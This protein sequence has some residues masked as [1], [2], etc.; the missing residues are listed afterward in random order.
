MVINAFNSGARIYMADFEDA[1]SPTWANVVGGQQ[2]LT[3][4]I[5]RTISLEQGEKRYSLNDEVA[6]LL[7]RP[8]GWHLQERHVVVDG[9]HVSGG[10]FD[11]GVYLARNA[12][13]LLERGSGP[14]FYLPKLESHLEARLWNDVFCFAQDRLG[15]PRGT[16]K[17]TVLIETILAAFEMEEILYELREHSAGLNAGR[18]DYIFSVIKKFRDRPEFVLPDRAQ[19]T[20]TVPFMRAYT[21]LLVKTCHRRGAHAIGGMA[22]FIPSRRDAEVNEVALARVTRGQAARGRRRLRRL[23]GRPSRPRSG[24]DGRVRRGARRAAE[25][26]RAAARGRRDAGGRSS[27][28]RCDARRDHG[29][30]RPRRTS[31]SASATSPRGY[32]ASVPLRSTT[33]WRTPR[34]PRSRAR[35]SGS[36]FA[37][38]ASSA[39]TSSGSSARSWPSSRTS[40]CTARRARS[41]RRWRCEEVFVDFLTLTAYAQLLAGRGGLMSDGT[42]ADDIALALEE[43][44]V[45][46]EI[47]PGS[48]LRQEHLSE[49]FQVSRTPV[50]EALRRLAA[51][52]LVTFEPN[53]GVR[54]RMLSRDEIR[55]AFMVR[56]ELESLATE[57]AT[58]KMTDDDL[59]ELERAER[60]FHRATEALVEMSHEGRQDLE[61]AR[62]WLHLN[63]SFHDVIYRAADVPLIERMAK[64]ARRTFLVK[65]VWATGADLDELYQKNDRQHR[66][67]RKAIAARSPEGARVL[68][69]EHVLSSGRL[70]EAILDKVSAQSRSQRASESTMRRGCEAAALGIC[71]R[72]FLARGSPLW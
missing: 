5:E 25:P 60:R 27:R 34:P 63:H 62:D 32:R 64:A 70:L 54:V 9:E 58:P 71:E 47:P 56:A 66:A 18:W 17:A 16:I 1:N 23:V 49:Q 55:E 22:A 46:G 67:I 52:G 2:N 7:V 53:R 68:A 29:G 35:R 42:K 24:R 15:I 10:L 48:T 44:I 59:A 38:G 12:E 39:P 50:R 28:R 8:R 72:R 20:M 41:S 30:G 11:F 19:V 26:A 3:D 37:T 21:E 43:A 45:A 13:R 33:S 40:R 51:L 36:G 14:Y 61:V 65:P 6:V 4:A 69:R 31:P 57:I